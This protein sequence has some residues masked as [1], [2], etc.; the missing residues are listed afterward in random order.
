MTDQFG[1]DK[2]I[3]KFKM[4]LELRILIC[5]CGINQNI[6]QRSFADFL[7]QK[8]PIQPSRIPNSHERNEQRPVSFFLTTSVFEKSDAFMT[9]SATPSETTGT[10]VSL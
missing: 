7:N 4:M 3:F 6:G 9:L 8:Q 2:D 1:A 10:V 5:L